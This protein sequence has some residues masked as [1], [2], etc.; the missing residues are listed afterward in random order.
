VIPKVS[1]GV[2]VVLKSHGFP[3]PVY[4]APEG[5][6]RTSFGDCVVFQRL[7]GS[8]S[9]GP[10]AASGDPKGLDG[11]RLASWQVGGLVTVYSRSPAPSPSIE[12][13]EDWG[14][15]IV[16]MVVCALIDWCR[17][18]LHSV[19][20]TAAGYVDESELSEEDRPPGTVYRL[21]FDVG[22]GVFRRAWDHGLPATGTIAA[23][24]NIPGAPPEEEDPP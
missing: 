15:H 3:L 8:D 14:D 1:S 16:S 19:A 18:N 21:Q 11:K 9:F 10:P 23:V 12:T 22:R 24:N 20:I 7:R 6:T 13:H 5:F 4:Y 17:D 2:E